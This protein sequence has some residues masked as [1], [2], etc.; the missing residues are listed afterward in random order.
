MSNQDVN[1]LIENPSALVVVDT[2]ELIDFCAQYPYFQNLRYLLV[3]KQLIIDSSAY[4][5]TLN[6]AATY[7]SDRRFLYNFLYDIND[8][9]WLN[10]GEDKDEIEEETQDI[11]FEI[12]SEPSSD[13]ALMITDEESNDTL[14]NDYLEAIE[15]EEEGTIQEE[16]IVGEN[17][18]IEIEEIGE[19]GEGENPNIETSRIKEDEIAE[20]EE[21]HAISDNNPP[22]S[23]SVDEDID[24][25]VKNILNKI[26]TDPKEGNLED[27]IFRIRNMKLGNAKK[28]RERAERIRL[29]KEKNLFNFHDN[30]EE[31]GE[32]GLEAKDLLGDFVP[33]AIGETSFSFIENPIKEDTPKEVIFKEGETSNERIERLKEVMRKK[34]L[35]RLRESVEAFFNLENE[36][37]SQKTENNALEDI[38][39]D[40]SFKEWMKSLKRKARQEIVVP[41]EDIEHLVNHSVEEDD[42]LMSEALAELLAKQGNK[43]RAKE[44]YKHLILKF[45]EK[46]AF[47]AEKIM[48]LS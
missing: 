32:G 46:K 18:N 44:M 28:E 21:E 9:P 3:K 47:F 33:P 45:P 43:A 38:P 27:A 37:D 15:E 35:E 26:G 34:H 48:D 22:Q 8:N 19:I 39:D 14:E 10:S 29:N 2:Q 1:D 12:V 17:P 31:I 20:K 40:I 6:M 25:R 13:D 5:K 24:L 42:E 7:S 16:E 23:P 36:N 11:D 30:L 4:E 41:A